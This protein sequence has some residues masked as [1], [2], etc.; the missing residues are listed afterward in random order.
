MKLRCK[1]RPLQHQQKQKNRKQTNRARD[2][3]Y[4]KVL[5]VQMK[6]VDLA[7]K[8]LTW[9]S[10]LRNRCCGN[11]DNFIEE[12]EKPRCEAMMQVEA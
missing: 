4:S 9:F 8:F 5:L 2:Y 10:F 12:A 7:T 11:W 3:S 6:V 1:Q